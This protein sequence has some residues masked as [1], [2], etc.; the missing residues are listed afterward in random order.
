[1]E[2]AA[3]ACIRLPFHNINTGQLNKKLIT[4]KRI[5]AVVLTNMTGSKLIISCLLS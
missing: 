4:A 5:I 1:M 2:P 3:K